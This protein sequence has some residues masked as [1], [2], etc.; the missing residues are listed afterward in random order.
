LC[1]PAE[2]QL[3]YPGALFLDVPLPLRHVPLGQLQMLLP[4][5]AQA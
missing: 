4:D 1:L 5:A 2:L 3:G